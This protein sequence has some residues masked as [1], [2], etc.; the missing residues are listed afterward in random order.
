VTRH[1]RRPTGGR[2]IAWA[3]A[4]ALAG[5]AGAAFVRSE[6]APRR[7]AAPVVHTVT[8]DATSYQPAQLVVHAGDTV[9][10][11]NK[12]LFPHTVTS[13]GRFDS[14]V[15]VN[16]TSWRF[17]ARTKGTFDYTCVFHPVMK[18]RLTVE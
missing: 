15:L 9:V 1:P 11:Q 16:G 5:A 2:L 12:D 17:V 7:A 13:T 10:W 6:A 3:S 4:L 8:I 14:D 18:G